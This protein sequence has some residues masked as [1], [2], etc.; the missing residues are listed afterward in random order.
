[1]LRTVCD[2]RGVQGNVGS[3]NK[4]GKEE[5]YM[6]V[7]PSDAMMLANA[8]QSYNL[9]DRLSTG[10]IQRAGIIQ[11][12]ESIGII[13]CKDSTGIVQREDS[14]GIVQREDSIG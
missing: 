2:Y 8:P 10:R 5:Q 7:D 9:A 4:R 6:L 12:E 1:M 14:I 3:V 13:Q 11:Q